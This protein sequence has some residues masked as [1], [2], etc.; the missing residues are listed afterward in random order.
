MEQIKKQFYHHY[1]RVNNNDTEIKE[2]SINNLKS[3]GP[4]PAGALRLQPDASL[5]CLFTDIGQAMEKA[6]A[7]ARL[8]SVGLLSVGKKDYPNCCNTGWIITKP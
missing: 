5:F 1:Y 3:C 7:G 2:I 6:K 8:I 4:K